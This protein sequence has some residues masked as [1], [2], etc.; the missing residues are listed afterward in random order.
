MAAGIPHTWGHKAVVSL[1]RPS[2]LNIPQVAFILDLPH[3][4]MPLKFNPGASLIPVTTDKG[5]PINRPTPV[6]SAISEE[7]VA[8]YRAQFGGASAAN[9]DGI[10]PSAVAPTPAPAAAASKSA[11]SKAD[12]KQSKVDLS[13]LPPFARVDLR[14]G[15]ITKVW[16][17]PE[18]DGLWCEEVDVGEPSPRLIA[19][20][21]R[22]FYTAEQMLGRRICVVC[23]LKPRTMRGFASAGMVLC[24]SNADRS[25]VEFV[26]PPVEANVGERLTCEGVVPADA[27]FPVPEVINP[28]KEGNPWTIVSG[29]LRTDASRVAT[30]GGLPLSVRGYRA[31]AP[32]QASAPIG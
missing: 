19:S 23:N 31:S 4:D 5:H 30:F 14:V 8:S 32:S 21:L 1:A 10:G 27:P 20:G 9:S 11:K 22:A 24:A 13:T 12:P 29:E 3:L 26:D 16:P 28:A 18:A 7:Q 2:A 6:F 17:H 25:I 15:L